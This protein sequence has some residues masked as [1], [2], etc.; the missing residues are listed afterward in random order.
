MPL[1]RI[2]IGIRDKVENELR[3]QNDGIITPVSEPSNWISALLVVTKPNGKVR[4]CLDHRPLNKAVKRALYM[5][6]TVDDIFP[7]WVM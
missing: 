3:L 7:S 4:L 6:P 5:I 2:P 1:R